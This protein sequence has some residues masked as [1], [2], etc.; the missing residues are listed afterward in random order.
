MPKTPFVGVS[1]KITDEELKKSLILDASQLIKGDEGLIV[2]T[3]APYATLEEKAMEV[4]YFRSLFVSLCEQFKIIEVGDLVYSE[5]V[6]HVRVLR[7]IMPT[8]V[9][10]VYVGT[11]ALYEHVNYIINMTPH[12]NVIPII[13]NDIKSDMFYTAGL[14]RQLINMMQPRVNLPNGA[15]MIIEQTEALTVVDVNTGGYVGDDN[16]EDT[17]Y[18]T[19]I[20]AAREIARQVRLRNIGGIVVVDF[21]D[22]EGENHS[23]DIVAE[24]EKALKGDRALCNVLPM[25]KFGLV[26]FTR[27]RTGMVPLTMMVKPCKHCHGAGYIRTPEFVLFD[28]RARLMDYLSCGNADMFVDMSFDLAEKLFS[29]KEFI[30]SIQRAFPDAKV[31]VTPHRSYH[32][33]TIYYHVGDGVYVPTE[34][35]TLLY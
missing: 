35:A 2:R 6:L 8:D 15:Y 12:D 23:N 3:A 5:S 22:M 4:E 7:D 1:R 18:Y 33:D 32:D 14:Y 29:W 26:E 20:L 30:K 16:M 10:K 34:N 11:K 19:N 31:H 28:M 24:L 25:S 9:E 13:L 27:K 21:I 17:A